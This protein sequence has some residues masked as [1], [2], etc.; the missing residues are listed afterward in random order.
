MS[1]GS[2]YGLYGIVLYE[3][4]A[5]GT[6]STPILLTFGSFKGSGKSNGILICRSWYFYWVKLSSRPP[7]EGSLGQGA[8]ADLCARTG[9]LPTS[10]RRSPHP[11]WSCPI[12][13]CLP[14][15]PERDLLL[16]VWILSSKLG[17]SLCYAFFMGL[18]PRIRPSILR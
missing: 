2:I 13:V 16:P 9:C 1:P 14:L 6:R 4:R 10:E 18:R 8:E 12:H 11:D 15:S 3:S 7:R 17:L 5:C